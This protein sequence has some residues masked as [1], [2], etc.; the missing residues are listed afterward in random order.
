[1]E[2]KLKVFV[3]GEK[4]GPSS[5]RA[6]RRVGAELCQQ[7]QA[8]C[9]RRILF[10]IPQCLLQNELSQGFSQT[11]SVCAPVPEDSCF[12]NAMSEEVL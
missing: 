12:D 11:F 4:D 5:C 8:I 3:P 6:T 2:Q 10:L 7:A 9:Y 1:M